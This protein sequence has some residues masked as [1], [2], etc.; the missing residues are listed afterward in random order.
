MLGLIFTT[1]T[2]I[3]DAVSSGVFIDNLQKI[4]THFSGVFLGDFEHANFNWYTV[5]NFSVATALLL[6][7]RGFFFFFRFR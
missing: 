7:Y 2:R 1:F 5:F 3:P 4:F 6:F